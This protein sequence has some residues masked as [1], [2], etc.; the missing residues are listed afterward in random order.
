MRLW[1]FNEVHIS[2]KWN[3]NT[4][5]V[6]TDYCRVPGLSDSLQTLLLNAMHLP[7]RA[8]TSYDFNDK[9]FFSI[10][11]I[12]T[13]Y[14]LSTLIKQAPCLWASLKFIT[15]GVFAVCHQPVQAKACLLSAE[16]YSQRMPNVE[17]NPQIIFQATYRCFNRPLCE[18]SRVEEQVSAL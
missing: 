5:T 12:C 14:I 6:F 8:C 17:C 18:K 3:L 2:L 1:I 13:C 10:I 7:M 16:N 15:N 9:P 4:Y 11:Y